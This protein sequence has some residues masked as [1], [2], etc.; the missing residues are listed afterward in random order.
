MFSAAVSAGIKVVVLE[1]IAD[2]AAAQGGDALAAETGDVLALDVD[3]AAGRG[4]ETARDDQQRGLAG[5]GRTHHGDEFTGV[6]G[7]VDAAQGVHLGDAGA[8]GAGE[9]SEFEHRC[10]D[11]QRRTGRG[12]G[13]GRGARGHDGWFPLERV[14]WGRRP[15]ARSSLIPKRSVMA[16]PSLIPDRS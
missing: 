2:A 15:M 9:R 8:V 12:H 10:V 14:L 11:R 16:G 1:D 4:V 13:S 3:L 7:D 5:A 6:H